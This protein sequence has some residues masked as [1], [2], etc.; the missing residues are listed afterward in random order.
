MIDQ[1]NILQRT[2][3][4][5]EKRGIIQNSRRNGRQAPVSSVKEGMHVVDLEYCVLEGSEVD[6]GALSLL[7]GVLFSPMI[8]AAGIRGSAPR[9]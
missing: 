7:S 4:L 1:A 2:F 9:S 8:R 3:S 5:V 6:V